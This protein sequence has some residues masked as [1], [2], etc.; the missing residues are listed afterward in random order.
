[1]RINTIGVK[2]FL[3]ITALNWDAFPQ[4]A[5]STE[6]TKSS[7]EDYPMKDRAGFME[8]MNRKNLGGWTMQGKGFWTVEQGELVGSQDPSEREDSWLFSSAQWSDFV[9]ELEFFVPE[10]CNTGVGIRMP[11][12]ST[13]S[14]DVHGYEVQ[15]SDLPQRKLTGSLLHHVESTGA[16]LHHPNQ[17][18]ALAIFCEGDHIRVYLN[19]RKILDEKVKGSRR[20]RIGLQVPKGEEFSKQVVRFRKLRVRDLNPIKSFI[21]A[22]YKGRPFVDTVYTLGAQ[23][24]PGKIECAY[25]DLGGEGVAYHDFESVNKGSGELNLKPDHQR[26]HAT[27]YEW[28][29][30]KQ[31]GVDASYTKD[32]AD[33]NHN[34]NYYVPAVNQLYVGW[35]ENNE[36]LNYTVNVQSAGTYKIDALYGNSDNTITFDVDQRPATVCKLPLNT[37]NFHSWNKANIGTITF[38]EPGL[39]LLTFHYNKG[40]NF[41]Y[42]EFTLVAKKTVVAK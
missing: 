21:P 33:F 18:N 27:P 22:S 9:L 25:Y 40:N 23:V 17:W 38:S 26:P 5:T 8:I 29:F 11:K 10:K 4:Q 13:G 15:I 42:F 16:N 34:N 14:P 28:E 31:E 39:H 20:G 35:T 12:D 19:Q 3:I 41:A 30:R 32:F 6:K 7:S 2:V 37:G 36:W 1:M 24:I